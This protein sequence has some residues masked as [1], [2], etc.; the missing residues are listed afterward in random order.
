MIGGNGKLSLK[1]AV[2]GAGAVVVDRHLP[3]LRA[4]GGRAV[5]LFDPDR[6]AAARAARLFGIPKIA[7]SAEQAVEADGVEAVLIASPN[8]FHRQQCDVALERGRHVLC[9]KPVALTLRDAEQMA[10]RAERRGLVLQVGFH[11]RFSSEHRCVKEV[12]ASG[13]AGEVKAFSG[14][15]CEPMDV[16]PGGVE[17]YR[18]STR[19]GGG[20]TLIDVG[21][22]RIDQILDLFG[23][24]A[25]VS[26]EMAS[27]LP[28]HHLDDSVILTLRMQSGAIGSLNWHRFS[29]AFASPMMLFG[30]KATLGCSA[31]ITGPYQSAPV[32]IYLDQSPETA[33]PPS[34]LALARPDRWWGE[35]QAGWISLWPP[36]VDTFQ[37][38][39]LSFQRSIVEGS[40]P[41]AGGDDGR[42]AVEV[43]QAAYRSYRER[44]TVRV[45]REP[46]RHEDPP[47]W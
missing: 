39:L 23:P 7:N 28:S 34:V 19:D 44:R 25:E 33:L 15:I 21:Q 47:T 30:T 12:L 41:V 2:L 20:F 16:I 38:Q 24:V 1:L 6:R 14:V 13:A 43:V 3:A 32:S 42:R 37:E 36:R 46:G 29:R 8:A 22:H 35:L 5:S 26:C 4:L 17:N 27:F 18:F 10:A 9:E 40:P 11:H 31:F 45:E